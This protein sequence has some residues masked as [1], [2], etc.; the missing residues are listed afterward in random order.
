MDSN[1][2]VRIVRLLA[3]GIDPTTGE[4]FPDD[5]PY[6]HPLVIRALY[7]VTQ[8]TGSSVA[9]IPKKS[10][11][12]KQMDNIKAGRP[13][14][15]GIRWTDGQRDDLATRFREGATVDELARHFERSRGAINSELDRQGL[16]EP[17]GS[18]PSSFEA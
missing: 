3:S 8:A 1:E 13:R 9:P 15:A 6:N 16:S 2:A 11:E 12:E 17:T 4:P 10:D 5:S 18:G 7:T 14:N